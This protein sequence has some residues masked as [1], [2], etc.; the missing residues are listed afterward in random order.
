MKTRRYRSDQMTYRM[1]SYNK[2]FTKIYKYIYKYTY[3]HGDTDHI[4]MSQLIPTRT[5]MS[6]AWRDV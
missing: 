5:I 1:R 3:M 6:S 2:I 4:R